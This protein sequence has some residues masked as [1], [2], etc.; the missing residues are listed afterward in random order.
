MTARSPFRE[1]VTRLFDLEDADFEAPRAVWLE[2]MEETFNAAL[3]WAAGQIVDDGNP[4]LA[5]DRIRAG[6]EK[7]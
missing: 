2:D 5:R 1:T 6:R 7:P 3:E 4:R